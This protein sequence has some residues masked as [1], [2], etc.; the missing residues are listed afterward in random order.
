MSQK[1]S[2][3]DDLSIAENLDFFAGVYGVPEEER[4]E[5]EALGA[6][7]LRA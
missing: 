1:F 2:L 6:F 3:Y 7:V 4:E 5:K